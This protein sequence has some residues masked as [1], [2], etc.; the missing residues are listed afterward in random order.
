LSA[1]AY[2]NLLQNIGLLIALTNHVGNFK[3]NVVRAIVIYT[4]N[5][6]RI[7]K[8]VII[9]IFCN[10]SWK[11]LVKHHTAQQIIKINQVVTKYQNVKIILII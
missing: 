2:H 3:F 7:H 1:V 11:H 9:T 8:L 6:A 5:Q 10:V 4:C